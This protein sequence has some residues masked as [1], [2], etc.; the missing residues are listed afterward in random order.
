MDFTGGHYD[1]SKVYG[2][3]DNQYQNVSSENA[4]GVDLT[5]DLP[6]CGRCRRLRFL[7]QRLVAPV[8]EH[9]TKTSPTEILS[10]TIFNPPVFKA[11]AGVT[12]SDENWSATAIVNHISGETDLS[13]GVPIHIPV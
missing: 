12:W 4:S 1:P 6:S 5:R 3:V 9:P 2:L 13:T 11:R 8:C 7:R 10:G